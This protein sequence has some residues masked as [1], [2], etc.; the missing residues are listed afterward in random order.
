[1]SIGALNDMSTSSKFNVDLTLKSILNNYK[2]SLSFLT[3]SKITDQV[4]SE[5]IPRENFNIP[6]NIKLAGPEFN[7]PYKIDLLL[8]T[9]PTLSALCFG[10]IKI[11]E[12]HDLFLQKTQFGWVIGG[13]GEICLIILKNFVV[14]SLE[15]LFTVL[16]LI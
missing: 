13:G 10:Q 6:K 11:D 3:I 16:N 4:P 14:Y 12:N 9:G 15:S 8:G 1:M 5:L 2:K 7:K